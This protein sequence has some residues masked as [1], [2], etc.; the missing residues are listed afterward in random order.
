MKNVFG[1]L[2]LILLQSNAYAI[3]SAVIIMRHAEKP[4]TGNVLSEEG[5]RRALNLVNFVRVDRNISEL[6][7]INFLF[8]AAPKKED[9][10]IR[11]I[12]TITPLAQSINLAINTNYIKDDVSR[13][14]QD[15]L[16]NSAYNNKVVL[17][18]WA[19]AKIAKLARKLGA[20]N[21][22]ED[23][24]DLDYDHV[25]ILKYNNSTT[26]SFLEI[27]QNFHP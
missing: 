9:S 13:L 23:W 4:A 24:D 7:A 1:I 27:S 16:I 18:A 8:A 2:I 5:Q 6:G 20:L 17:I 25:W 14:A 10:S 11:S 19:H 15:L 21:S 12:Q 26:P 22:P 3:P